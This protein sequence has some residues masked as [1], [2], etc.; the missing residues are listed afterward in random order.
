M[1]TNDAQWE[2]LFPHETIFAPGNMQMTVGRSG[3]LLDQCRVA[4][5]LTW[6]V[7]LLSHCVQGVEIALLCHQLVKGTGFHKTAVF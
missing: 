2:L 5:L 6:Q 7:K 3:G 1:N 4:A